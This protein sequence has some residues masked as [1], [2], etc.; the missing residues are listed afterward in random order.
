ML[1]VIYISSVPPLLLN[2]D[3]PW[4]MSFENATKEIHSVMR[5]HGN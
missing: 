1:S 3:H 2:K 5:T 4:E